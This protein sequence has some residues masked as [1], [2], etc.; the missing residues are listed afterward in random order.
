MFSFNSNAVRENH[1]QLSSFLLA[2]LC[3]FYP[4]MVQCTSE[5]R[6]AVSGRSRMANGKQTAVLEH[7]LRNVI[8][9][10]LQRLREFLELSLGAS[11]FNL[12]LQAFVSISSRAHNKHHFEPFLRLTSPGSIKKAHN[13]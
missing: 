6:K 5:S 2:F 9:E 4:F 1:F 10:I 8:H 7:I 11:H 13:G 12:H 3:Y